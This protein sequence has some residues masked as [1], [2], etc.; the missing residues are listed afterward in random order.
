MEDLALHFVTFYS[1]LGL[2]P[3]IITA[4]ASEKLQL[5]EDSGLKKRGCSGIALKLHMV[6]LSFSK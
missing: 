4:I 6:T 1:E 5:S 2:I 3:D